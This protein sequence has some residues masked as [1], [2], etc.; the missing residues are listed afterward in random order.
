M[1]GPYKIIELEGKIAVLATSKGKGKLQTNIDLLTHY[2]Q[3]EERIP[4]KLKKL[5]DPSPLAGPQQT[6]TQTL[7]HSTQTP[8]SEVIPKPSEAPSMDCKAQRPSS[9]PEILIRDIWTGRRRET[10]WSKIG[11][12][13]IYSENLMVLA[14]GEQLE[15]EIVNGY[16]TMVGRK[17]GALVI[18]TYLM[19]SLWQGTHKGGLRRLDLFNHDVAAGA[20]C[21]NGHWTLIIMYLKEMRALFL[22]PFGAT[23]EQIQKCKDVTR[24]LVRQKCPAVGRWACTTVG[25][26]KQQ[27]AVSCGVFVCKLAEQILLKEAIQYPVDHEGVAILR[28]NIA[29]SL[30]NN[31]DDLSQ[32]CR[33]CGELSSGADI[34]DWDTGAAEGK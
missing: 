9:D 31:S 15:G 20:V 19:T 14:P 33:A 7:I 26:P 23:D 30:L 6:H 27:D 5:S 34:D 16:L 10:L 18:D 22:D 11:P 13:K 3:P 21:H 2:F 25:H 28:L 4:A 17:A 29:I 1:L 24:T 8:T 12:Y 32:L